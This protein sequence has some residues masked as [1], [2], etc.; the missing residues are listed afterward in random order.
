MQA[1]GR[2]LVKQNLGNHLDF[3]D[4]SYLNRGAFLALL[5][6][7]SF[8]VETWPESVF[9]AVG[10]SARCCPRPG[11]LTRCRPVQEAA[12]GWLGIAEPSWPIP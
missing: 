7:V 4:L 6:C 11:G 2:W 8:A 10:L 1:S 12:P 9:P 3:R 5:T